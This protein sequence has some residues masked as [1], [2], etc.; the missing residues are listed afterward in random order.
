MTLNGTCS[1]RAVGVLALHELLPLRMQLI[2]QTLYDV[3][4]LMPALSVAAISARASAWARATMS[5]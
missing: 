4:T 5:R 2:R 1:W 3:E